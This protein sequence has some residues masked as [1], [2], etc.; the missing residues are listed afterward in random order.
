MLHYISR[1]YV[2]DSL[3]QSL[4]IHVIYQVSKVGGFW[5]AFIKNLKIISKIYYK[6][7]KCHYWIPAT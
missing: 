4:H 3:N 2:Y 1:K 5:K 7:Q 6:L